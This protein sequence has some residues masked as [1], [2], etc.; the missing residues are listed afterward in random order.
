MA[1]T[2]AQVLREFVELNQRYAHGE[3]PAYLHQRWDDLAQVIDHVLAQHLSECGQPRRTTRAPLRLRVQFLSA[4]VVGDGETV[5]VS[6]GGCAVEASCQLTPGAEI[7]L[8]VQLPDRLGSLH[9]AGWVCWSAPSD[10]HG[11]RTG[12]AFAPLGDWERELLASA[13]LGDVAPRF[14]GHA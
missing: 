10:R 3:L 13:V 8:T 7:E 12:V 5:D 2:M 4:G 1:T 11:W 6:C 9:P 14:I